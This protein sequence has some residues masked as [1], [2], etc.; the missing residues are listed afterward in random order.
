MDVG[1]QQLPPPAVTHGLGGLHTPP[2]AV[3]TQTP[4]RRHAAGAVDNIMEGAC[5]LGSPEYQELM[6][7]PPFHYS[8]ITIDLPIGLNHVR[9]SP[10]PR[11]TL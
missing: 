8:T 6:V 2:P 5:A 11:W 10:S 9:N 1:L 4:Q 7:T 3:L